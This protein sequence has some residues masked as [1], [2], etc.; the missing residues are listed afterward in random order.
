MN[1][2]S[3]FNRSFLFPSLKSMK[4]HIKSDK[5][6]C[7][8]EF[9]RANRT[10]VI[11]GDSS[12]SLIISDKNG[13]LKGLDEPFYMKSVYPTKAEIIDIIQRIIDLEPGIQEFEICTDGQIYFHES[14]RDKMDRVEPEPSGEYYNTIILKFTF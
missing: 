6:K 4:A 11:Q 7:F 10:L 8:D 2:I 5:N 1:A 14:L 12:P 9:I 3:I 13:R